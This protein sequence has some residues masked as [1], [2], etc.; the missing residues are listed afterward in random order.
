MNPTIPIRFIKNIKLYLSTKNYDKYIKVG[1]FREIKKYLFYP[2]LFI[3]KAIIKTLCA[4]TQVI[5]A[6]PFEIHQNSLRKS[7]LVND[8]SFDS[9]WRSQAIVLGGISAIK[10]SLEA[11]KSINMEVLCVVPHLTPGPNGGF[12]VPLIPISDH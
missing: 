12:P 3:Q 9:R 11:P 7:K 8:T 6:A 4:I 1:H 2:T 10:S 5:V